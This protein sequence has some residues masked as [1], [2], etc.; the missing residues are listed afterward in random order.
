MIGST[1]GKGTFY[2]S[3]GDTFKEIGKTTDSMCIGVDFGDGNDE[4][5]QCIKNGEATLTLKTTYKEFYY[6]R[7]GKRHIRYYKTKNG[8]DP[9]ILRKLLGGKE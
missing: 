9:K 6:K 2:I 5:V 3:D 7:K 4:C 1:L 8:F